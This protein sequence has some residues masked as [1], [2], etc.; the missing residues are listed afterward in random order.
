MEHRSIKREKKK[1]KEPKQTNK[2]GDLL[3]N[4]SHNLSDVA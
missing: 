4:E 3:N 2:D 1:L